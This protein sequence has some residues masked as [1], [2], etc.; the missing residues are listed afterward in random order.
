MSKF[1]AVY[2]LNALLEQHRY[3]VS[4]Q[5]IMD[6]LECSVAT[7]KRVIAT[8]R[9]TCQMPIIYSHEHKGYYI[10]RDHIDRDYNTNLLGFWFSQD[11]LTML[12]VISQLLEHIAPSAL[13]TDLDRMQQRLRTALQ[14][15]TRTEV[16]K[17]IHIISNQQR[18]IADETLPMVAHAVMRETCLTISY[19]AHSTNAVTRRTISPLRLVYYRGNWYVNAWCHE[20]EAV[21][22]FALDAIETREPSQ[23]HFHAEN[24]SALVDSGYG[25]FSGHA[26]NVAQLKFSPLVSRWVRKETWHPNQRVTE[27]DDGSLL[28]E[29]PYANA[30]ELVRDVLRHGAD[31]EVIAPNS[32][33]QAVVAELDR[34][35]SQYR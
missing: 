3:P 6:E 4:I 35:V 19:H 33:R 14:G 8:L 21:R 28:L 31:V 20:K 22:T 9:T 27:L 23:E 2:K 18:R 12:A 26:D 17:K 7:A 15:D 29:I 34:A 30:T 10:A 32:L 25:I 1:D 13:K 11:E 24:L 5:R 16:D